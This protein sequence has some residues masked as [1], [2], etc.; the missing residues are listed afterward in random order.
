MERGKSQLRRRA[1]Y[2]RKSSEEGLEQDAAAMLSM[3]G[4]NRERSSVFDPAVAPHPAPRSALEMELSSAEL[5]QLNGAGL[6]A[7]IR[8]ASHERAPAVPFQASI[9]SAA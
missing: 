1:I 6:F 5:H 3:T 4:R 7:S 8:S 9:F 2:T